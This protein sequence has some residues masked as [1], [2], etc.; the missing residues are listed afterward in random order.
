MGKVDTLRRCPLFVGFTDVGLQILAAIAEEKRLLANTPIFVEG[1]VG[2]SMY[3]LEQGEVRVT[4]RGP[5]GAEQ[6]VAR[7]QSGEAFGELSLLGAGP[8]LVS[9]HAASDCV[10]L[11]IGLKEFAHLQR[12]KPQACLKL[13]MAI[14]HGF[15]KRLQADRAAWR[16]LLVSVA[17]VRSRSA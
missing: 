7:I 4:V 6:E 9:A 14:V 10:L 12:K 11:E 8:R 13:L 3:I 15:G 16:D 5:G 17:D 2:E 1:M